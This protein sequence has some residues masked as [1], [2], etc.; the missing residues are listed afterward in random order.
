MSVKFAL[1]FGSNP[2]KLLL[3]EMQPTHKHT[4]RKTPPPCNVVI[5]K[6]NFDE[7]NNKV[8]MFFFQFYS[9]QKFINQIFSFQREND[10]KKHHKRSNTHDEDFFILI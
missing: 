6:Q 8:G 1:N 9:P 10:E 4:Y 7:R 3:R 2:K 5:I